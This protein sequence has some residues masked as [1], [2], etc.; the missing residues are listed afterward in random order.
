MNFLRFG[1]NKITKMPCQQGD[2][3]VDSRI[4]LTGRVQYSWAKTLGQ[5][6][7]KGG[8]KRRVWSGSCFLEI[9]SSGNVIVSGDYNLDFNK[10]VYGV[11][12]ANEPV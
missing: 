7:G 4:K 5:F 11:K 9:N 12:G 1:K 2:W 8:A 6:N 10:G 3:T